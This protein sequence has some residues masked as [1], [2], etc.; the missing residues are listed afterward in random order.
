MIEQPDPTPCGCVEH[1]RQRAAFA[2]GAKFAA[3]ELA[4]MNPQQLAFDQGRVE[5][6]LEILRKFVVKMR[7]RGDEEGARELERLI[8]EGRPS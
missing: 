6:R 2:D 5:G 7:A 3:V 4:K 8:G 1:E